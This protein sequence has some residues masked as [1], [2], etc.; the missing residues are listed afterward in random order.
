MIVLFA[1]IAC[2]SVLVSATTG[3]VVKPTTV[4]TTRMLRELGLLS[5]IVGTSF[6][7]H[8]GDFTSPPGQE[9]GVLSNTT[10]FDDDEE[11]SSSSSG[12]AMK[13]EETDDGVNVINTVTGG[14]M[15]GI[16]GGEV[17]IG[18]NDTFSVI[19]TDVSFYANAD[20]A[21]VQTNE[22]I[23]L[24]NS[25]TGENVLYPDGT[26]TIKVDLVIVETDEKTDEHLI[27]YN[28]STGEYYDLPGAHLN[29]K[30]D[31]SWS[32]WVNVDSGVIRGDADG[33][34]TYEDKEKEVD[35]GASLFLQST[36][37]FLVSFIVV[38]IQG[39]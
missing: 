38:A 33:V 12:P 22:G 30:D 19:G 36:V 9:E 15:L 21:I 18:N 34:V 20:K 28:K 39:A 31:G 25:I 6:L 23:T 29:D 4:E 14:F 2:N 7:Q 8:V 11:L 17:N 10:G 13:P 35:S 37:L 3:G 27:L 1:C 26:I 24:Y 5:G 32:I 16:P